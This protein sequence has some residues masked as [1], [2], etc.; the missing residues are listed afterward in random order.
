MMKKIISAII[1]L[2]MMVSILSGCVGLD[3][4]NENNYTISFKD[5]SIPLSPGQTYQIDPIIT[6]EPENGLEITWTSSDN[7][8][9]SVENGLVKGISVGEAA[10]T[11]TL[12]GGN[13]ASCKVFV[14]EA[15]END[16]GPDIPDVDVE[17]GG[18][19]GN[20]C[21]PMDLDLVDGSG[22]VN[23]KDYLGKV[24]ILNFWGTW[25]GPCKSELPSFDKIADEYSENVVVLA[26]HTTDAIK[27]APA[28]INAN[29]PDSNII[30]AK[31][32][33]GAAVFDA[34]YSL[35]G[36]TGSYPTTFIIDKDGIVRYSEVGAL[37]YAKLKSK[38]EMLGVK[39]NPTEDIPATDSN[40]YD[41]SAVTITFYHTMSVTKLQPTLD[42]YIA[43]F[44]KLYPNITIKHSAIGAYDDVF[45]VIR[46]EIPAGRGPN[47]AYCYSD[48]VASYMSADAVVSLDSLID[49]K[50]E[51]TDAIGNKTILG[52][53]D[54]QKADFVPG[55]Y[56]EGRVFDTN[57]TMYTLPM[58]KST[59][60]LYYDKTFFE[61]YGL[62]VPTTWDELEEVC[63]K[64]KAIDPDCI[65]L[66]Y[67]SEANWFITMCMQY[68]P[69]GA[70]YTQLSST[71]DHFNFDNATTRAFVER[72]KRWYDLGY[73]TTEGLY[74]S[75][76]SDLFTNTDPGSP[77]CY[78]VIGSTGGAYYQHPPMGD[79]GMPLFETGM[80]MIPQVD[81]SNPQVVLQGPSLC[82]FKKDNIQE[83]YASWLFVEFLTTNP[84]FQAAFSMASSYA[85]VI[86]S[87]RDNE[88]FSNWLSRAN[89]FDNLA[90]MAV[91]LTLSQ[92]NAYFVSPAFVGSSLARNQVGLLMINVFSSPRT[93]I[94]A[95]IDEAFKKAIEECEYYVQQ[96]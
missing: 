37:S 86:Q 50:A 5:G 60:A 73:F 43:E 96:Y 58:S 48:H 93:D 27:D 84:E 72:F 69:T 12:P 44:N 29:Y 83:V 39:P 90:A 82:I 62:K 46:T 3:N 49:S 18:K 70:L 15:D 75:Y 1:L 85:P 13:S 59:E 8:V 87:V 14:R 61:E 11:A 41:G 4:K 19:V 89:G 95:L 56:A 71:K 67:D 28:Y 66:G 51:V 25:C 88:V 2:S 16:G 55:F 34:Y 80:A 77:R 63:A 92:P 33:K 6:P 65:P 94:E 24:V 76:S 38:I 74:G 10:I 47:I 7:K 22:S 36:G 45:D 23:V 21:P 54:A 31:D 57:G 30:F 79:N 81:P 91:D 35:L 20:K 40:S 52:L 26:V 42:L 78:M 64:I 9:A 32:E 53:T 17:Y 68:D